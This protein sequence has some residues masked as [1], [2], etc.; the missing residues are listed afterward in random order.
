MLMKKHIHVG[1][2]LRKMPEPE[3]Q[4]LSWVDEERVDL[5]QPGPCLAKETIGQ[6][7]RGKERIGLIYKNKVYGRNK[8]SVLASSKGRS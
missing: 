4:G 1:F 6:R 2:Q 3:P 7:L 8:T 5:I